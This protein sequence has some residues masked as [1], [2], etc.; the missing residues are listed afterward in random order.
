M[1]D[2]GYGGT[3]TPATFRRTRFGG[4]VPG[5]GGV[6]AGMTGRSVRFFDVGDG[7]SGEAGGSGAE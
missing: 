3:S 7:Q 1:R 6:A 4:S 2:G 5:G